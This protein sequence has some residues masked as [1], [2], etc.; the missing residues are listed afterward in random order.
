MQ[1]DK[2]E[3]VH[4][5]RAG[6]ISGRLGISM[7]IFQKIRVGARQVTQIRE[8]GI[9]RIE[10][11]V[12]PA[13]AEQAATFDTAD[14]A[15]VAEVLGECQRQGVRI[16]S[17]HNT[18]ALV[19][20]LCSENEAERRDGVARTVA[21][22]RTAAQMGAGVLVTH[23]NPKKE[24]TRRSV[25]DILLATEDLPLVV[26]FENCGANATIKDVLAFLDEAGCERL[27][28]TLDIGHERDADRVNP[29]VKRERARA[30]LTQCGRHLAHVH[31]HETFA[32][33]KKPDHR[34]PLHK[35]G[36]IEWGEIF[37][38]LR[39][40]EYAGTILFED[41]RGEDPEDWIRHTGEFPEKFVRRYGR[42]NDQS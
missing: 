40:V 21:N 41:G 16:V 5:W 3:R 33:E 39:Q 34:P 24:E 27:R 2:I 32:I 23:L 29:F 37:A 38:G 4:G 10:L 9:A 22:A 17:I 18:I 19:Q 13:T 1:T 14:K 42:D 12:R 26:A 31:L 28:M 35:D 15:Q 25:E 8:A 36:I 20:A 7:A 11:L 6:Q 30:A